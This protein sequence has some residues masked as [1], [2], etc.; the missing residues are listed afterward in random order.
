MKSENLPYV[1]EEYIIEAAAQL[2]KVDSELLNKATKHHVIVNGKPYPPKELL[3]ELIKVIEARNLNIDLGSVTGGAATNLVFENANFEVVEFKVAIPSL[4]DIPLLIHNYKK[5]IA[6]DNNDGEVYKWEAVKQFQTHWDFRHPDF[7]AML[8]QSFGKRQNLM[9]QVS[10]SFLDILANEYPNEAREMFEILYE[11]GL[12]LD[13]RIKEFQA[14][15]DEII[16]DVSAKRGKK[17]HHQQDERAIS[18]YL[19]L[20]Y[21][22]DD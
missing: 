10:S 8:K 11:E 12:E 2:D 21:P 13:D 15:S 16:K 5:L 6:Q 22:E 18:F 19:A 20:Y 7:G 3:R 9:Y 17:L 14:R 1:L 4:K